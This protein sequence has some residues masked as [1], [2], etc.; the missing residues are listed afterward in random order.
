VAIS[1]MSTAIVALGAVGALVFTSITAR[2]A[3]QHAALAEQGQ[4]TDRYTRAVDQ[5]V[6]QGAEHLQ[7]RLGG[8]YAL[9][10]I[11]RDSPRDQPTIVEVLSAFIRTTLPKPDGA[12]KCPRQALPAD[13][14]AAFVVLGRRDRAHDG[15][16]RTDVHG[17][18]L[19]DADLTDANLTD[20]NLTDANLTGA[21]LIGADLTEAYLIAANLTMADMHRADLTGVTLNTAHLVA[22]S[23]NGAFLPNARLSGAD[24]TSVDLNYSSLI[25]ADLTSAN[26]EG[27]DLQA[28]DHDDR[29]DVEGVRTV[30]IRAVLG[31]RRSR[32]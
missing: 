7:V 29:T 24:L 10:R 12:G 4:I 11:T 31:G 23:L 21:D 25:G 20:A 14:E 15:T 3:Q 27:A 28:T 5:I 19:A 17:T 2:A 26:L 32:P 8:I 9:E 1:S 13:V 30:A 16:A 18:C 6:Q 22:A